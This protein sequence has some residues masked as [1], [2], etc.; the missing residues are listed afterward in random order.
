MNRSSDPSVAAAASGSVPAADVV[1][2]P[3]TG[4][5]AGVVERLKSLIRT[6]PDFPKP[7]ILFRDVTTLFEDPWGF[8]ETID[9]FVEHYRYQPI[10][11][12]VAIESRGFILGGALAHHLHCGL[13]VARKRGK[14]PHLV[15][16]EEYELEYGTD[17]IE[18][19]RT[20][21]RPGLRCLVVDDLLA[22]GG[23]CAAAC[24]L[25]ERLEGTV[26]GCGFVIDLPELG[27]SQLLAAK[28]DVM[29]L[30]EFAGH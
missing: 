20:A 15:E 2:G 21:I 16:R 4:R 14:L 9:A 3:R 22:T 12:V 1:R 17:C 29:T 10:D 24:R 25:V 30:V 18:V 13:I 6:I 19:H 11:R 27:G 23:T 28:Y 7:G 26:V 8:Q 5:P